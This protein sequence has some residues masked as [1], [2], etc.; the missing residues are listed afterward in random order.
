[1]EGVIESLFEKG[2]QGLHQALHELRERHPRQPVPEQHNC[3]KLVAQGGPGSGVQIVTGSSAVS[4]DSGCVVLVEEERV[5]NTRHNGWI[6][7]GR[8]LVRRDRLSKQPAKSEYLYK[9]CEALRLA[10]V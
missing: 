6:Q 8:P 4:L 9:A 7:L 2:Q 1:M 3:T 5:G 10:G